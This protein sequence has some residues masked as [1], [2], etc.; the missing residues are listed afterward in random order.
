[1]AHWRKNHES[2]GG[3]NMLRHADLYDEK[4][5]NAEGHDCYGEPIVLVER[6]TVDRV[7]SREKPKGERRN[8]LHFKGKSKPLGMN[9]T[10]CET[11]A[12]LSGSVDTARWV[13]LTIQLYVDTAARYPSGKTGPAIRIR[14]FRPKAKADTAALPDVPEDVRE[15]IE[16]AQS[17]AVEGRE[18]GSDDVP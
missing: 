11:V 10:N 18:P 2:S 3:A 13:G 14:P 12:A 5:S 6:V 7:T 17:A 8:F 16:E 4:A 9:V 1:M 15:R